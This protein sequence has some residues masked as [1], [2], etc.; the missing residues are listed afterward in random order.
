MTIT[1]ITF[2][3]HNP[4]WGITVGIF[5]DD[6]IK[7]GYMEGLLIPEYSS[8]DHKYATKIA[9]DEHQDALDVC[10]EFNPNCLSEPDMVMRLVIIM[11]AELVKEFRGKG[12]SIDA[13]ND[14]IKFFSAM[15][16]TVI[17][18]QPHPYAEDNPQGVKKL[19]KHWMKCGFKQ[20]G[21]TPCFFRECD[22]V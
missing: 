10:E 22:H 1:R 17:V 2:S 12:H 20:C 15:P 16:G 13:M 3:D 19:Q 5:N 9:D 8:D 11:K 21:R 14:V 6:D 4:A 7:I 18:L